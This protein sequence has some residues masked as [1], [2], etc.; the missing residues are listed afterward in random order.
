MLPFSIISTTGIRGAIKSLYY[1]FRHT[2]PPTSLIFHSNTIT[3]VDPATTFSIDG[4]VTV[5]LYNT[6]A[7]HPRQG[8]SVFKT[9]AGSS[10]SHT[11]NGSASIGPQS[12]IHVEGD[13]SLGDLRLNSF[14]RILCENQIE[15]GDRT[16]IAWNV[17]LIDSNRHE[18]TIDDEKQRKS[19]PISIGD[20]VWIGHDATITKGVT[21]EDGAIVA[22]NSAVLDDVP[23]NTIVGGYPAEPLV[24]GNIDWEH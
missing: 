22:S 11:G 8:K 13:L 23:E 14:V 2:G 24:T 4:R 17:Q 21:I 5:G 3:D 12:V 9:T 10:V 19:A 16:S 18:L 15:I 1:S 7:S 6:G 20:D